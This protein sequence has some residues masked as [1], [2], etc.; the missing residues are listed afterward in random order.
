MYINFYINAALSPAFPT[1]IEIWGRNVQGR[2][3]LG[4]KCLGEEMDLEQNVPSTEME[5]RLTWLSY[6][7][8]DRY[9]AQ[10]IMDWYSNS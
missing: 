6:W 5:Y 8:T 1:P 9:S 10:K 3:V 2:N 4:A 7:Y